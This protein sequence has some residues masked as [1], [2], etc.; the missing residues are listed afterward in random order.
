MAESSDCEP[1]LPSGTVASAV[2]GERV[3][4]CAII[5]AMDD[6]SSLQEHVHAALGPL[7][8]TAVVY[9]Y[10]SRARGTELPSSDVDLAVL[11]SEPIG[12]EALFA[13]REDLSL[14]LQR[15]VDLIDLQHAPTVLQKEVVAHG[16]LLCDPDRT[17]RDGFEAFVLGRY[18]RL[19]EERREILDRV[20]HEHTILGPPR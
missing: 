4:G 8:A 14:R 20:A 13:L 17:R 11:A 10:G 16:Q 5:L 3:R 15:D 2:V 6:S 7:A 12:P 1:T 18:A 19:N 9:L